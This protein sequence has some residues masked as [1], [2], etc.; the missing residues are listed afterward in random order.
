MATRALPRSSHMNVDGRSTPAGTDGANSLSPLLVAIASKP[1]LLITYNPITGGWGNVPKATLGTLSQSVTTT[2]STVGLQPTARS[3]ALTLLDLLEQM[4]ELDRKMA[5]AEWLRGG[6]TTGEYRWC[7]RC[8][9]PMMNYPALSR[10]DNKSDI[11]SDCGR[12]EAIGRGMVP[13]EEWPIET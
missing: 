3:Y 10:V 4:E 13:V 6:S 7:P 8:L 12:D 11:C 5:R 1:L 2:I 9:G